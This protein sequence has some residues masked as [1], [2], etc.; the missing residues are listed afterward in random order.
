MVNSSLNGSTAGIVNFRCSKTNL[1]HSHSNLI[2]LAPHAAVQCVAELIFTYD[3]L[4]NFCA[5][6][7]NVLFMDAS[8]IPAG[9][10]LR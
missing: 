8:F 9:I 6:L 5:K 4:K 10:M 3:H 2:L 7:E 1:L